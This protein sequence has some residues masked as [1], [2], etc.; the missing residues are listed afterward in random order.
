M[1]VYGEVISCTDRGQQPGLLV[2]FYPQ[3]SPRGKRGTEMLDWEYDRRQAEEPVG[4]GWCP[5]EGDAS[6][7]GMAGWEKGYLGWAPIYLPS[8]GRVLPTAHRTRNSDLSGEMG[9][10]ST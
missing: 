6:V 4:G 9:A 2:T 5:E 1:E 10:L 3:P 8:E 7:A